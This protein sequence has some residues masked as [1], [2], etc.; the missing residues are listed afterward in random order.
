MVGWHH[1]PN[2]HEFEQALG[3]GDREGSLVCCSPWGCKES[4]TTEQ[5]N[6]NKYLND[7]LDQVD[8]IDIYEIS[9][10]NRIPLLFRFT[11]DFFTLGCKT[12]LSEFK[13]T[14]I[15]SSIFSD[16]SG[17]KIKMNYKKTIIKTTSMWKL[18]N[19]LLDIQWI[20]EDIKDE[21]K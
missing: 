5:L 15:M 14:E 17:M 2:G 21:I 12:N 8:L 6:N 13:K 9:H 19:M 11:Q 16:H 7:S 18:T 20:S 1:R 4:D 10:S 3:V